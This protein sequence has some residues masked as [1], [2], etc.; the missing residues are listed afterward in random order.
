MRCTWTR[1]A[2]PRAPKP[3]TRVHAHSPN[4]AG[5]RSIR[6]R[7]SAHA[8]NLPTDRSIVRSRYL[9]HPSPPLPL[10]SDNCTRSPSRW[11]P[12]K[13]ARFPKSSGHCR[14]RS[15]NPRLF[16]ANALS[17]FGGQVRPGCT[18]SPATPVCGRHHNDS[19]SFCRNRSIP[20]LMPARIFRM[21]PIAVLV[22][23]HCAIGQRR[24]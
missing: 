5:S 7:S 24:L 1:H 22:I 2:S 19:R 23:P 8:K 14:G 12:S 16:R 9:P 6:F 15:V 11:D 20:L 17:N 18:A 13:R 4:I 21:R 10:A 3:S